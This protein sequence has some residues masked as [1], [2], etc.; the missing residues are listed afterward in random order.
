[1]F[2]AEN[3]AQSLFSWASGSTVAAAAASL[4]A[5]QADYQTARGADGSL[6]ITATAQGDGYG[7]EWANMLTT[8]KQTFASAAAGDGIDD[9]FGVDGDTTSAFGVAAYL[10]AI[11]LG[12]GTAVVAIQDSADDAS[13]ADLTGGVFTDITAATSERIQTAT[14]ASTRRYLR[15]NVTGTFTDLV[16]AVSVVRYRAQ[17]PA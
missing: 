17:P 16:V 15:V 2:S 4:R 5:R 14:D 7:L 12:S 9:F 1:V 3:A 8:G 11:S 10:H 6:A 13:Y